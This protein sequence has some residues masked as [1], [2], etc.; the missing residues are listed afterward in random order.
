MR[1]PWL[2]IGS[3]AQ[4]HWFPEART[5]GDIDLL[6][7]AKFDDN[8]VVDAKWHDVS[9][10]IIDINRD[11][12][13]ADPDTLYTLKVS[14]AHWNV[15]WKK[16]MF[17]I[18]FLS[19]R[20]KFNRELY[21]KLIKVWAEIHGQKKVNLNKPVKEFFTDQVEREY[22]HDQL[23]TLVAFNSKP[24]HEFIR[25]DLAKAWCCEEMFNTLTY[26]RRLETALEEIMATAIERFCLTPHSTKIE[27]LH[28]VHGCYFKLVTSMST[29]W[30]SRFLIFNQNKLLIERKE[31]WMSKII[32]AL[33]KLS[34]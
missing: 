33:N 11:P 34:I 10:H 19:E 13:F 15:H 4:Y 32:S 3:V 6:T 9:Q 8:A 18:A 16:T 25:P 28:A 5:P 21:D 29:G 23:H 2:I 1:P 27:I 31:K 26:E 17:D 12:V 14:H 20:C 7:P 24:M 30:F 22:D